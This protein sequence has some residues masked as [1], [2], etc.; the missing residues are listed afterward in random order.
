LIDH[1]NLEEF[2]DAV[3]YDI[4]D[5]SDTGTA[6][7][8]ALSE[9]TGGPVLEIACGTGR[10]CIP[11]A[12]LGFPVTGVDIVP[13]MLA[14]ARHKSAGF[15]TRWVE[16]DARTFDLGEQFRLIF[17]TGNAFQAFLTRSDQEALLER[18]HAHLHKDGLFA[19]ETRNPRWAHLVPT[20]PNRLAERAPE[21]G[22]F[23]FLETRDQEEDGGTYTDTRGRVVRRSRTQRYDHVAQILHW[24]TYRRWHEDDQEQT[25]ATRIA[26]RF[27]FPQELQALLHYNG[28]TIIR[29]YGDWNLE[30]LT[31]ASPSIIVVCR[32]QA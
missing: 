31:A 12:R 2:G 11:I 15:P 13:G 10:V 5:P 30:P 3:T 22:L 8:T 25:K 24:T 23:A 9:E 21:E 6:F 26:V 7:Y 4:E 29:Q 16:G 27:T 14:Q 19:F 20:D 1:D 32:K 17:L 28:F 18:V